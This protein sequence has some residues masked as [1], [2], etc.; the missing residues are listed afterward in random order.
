MNTDTELNKVETSEF[1]LPA[2]A[3]IKTCLL[4][5]GLLGPWV[6]VFALF[7]TGS[8][9]PLVVCA[10]LTAVVL[11]FVQRTSGLL[12]WFLAPVALSTGFLAAVFFLFLWALSTAEFG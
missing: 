10:L 11:V 2:N 3:A 1:A 12:S 5:A 4:L 8:L 9:I 6:A 7:M